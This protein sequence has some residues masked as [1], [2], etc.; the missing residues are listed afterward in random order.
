MTESTESLP[1]SLDFFLN[2]IGIRD[3]NVIIINKSTDSKGLSDDYMDSSHGWLPSYP[4]Q[5]P[6]F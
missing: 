3:E 5:E 6:P 4:G 1:P 2:H